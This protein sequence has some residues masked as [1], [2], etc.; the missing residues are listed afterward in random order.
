MNCSDLLFQGLRILNLIIRKAVCKSCWSS[1][2]RDSHSTSLSPLFNLC[3]QIF[4]LLMDVDLKRTIQF[5]LERNVAVVVHDQ[6]DLN[7]SRSR[8]VLLPNAKAGLKEKEKEKASS[9]G[10]GKTNATSQQVASNNDVISKAALAQ[11]ARRQRERD[12]KRQLAKR[13][14]QEREES[15]E[16]MQ[17]TQPRFFPALIPSRR[18]RALLERAKMKAIKVN[19]I[20]STS[21]STEKIENAPQQ[22]VV[23]KALASSSTT[24][25]LS[26]STSLSTEKTENAPQRT[27]VTKALVSSSTTAILSQEPNF[28]H[29]PINGR[30][31][32][33]VRN[34]LSQPK[35]S[36]LHSLPPPRNLGI[37]PG[38]KIIQQGLHFKALGG[39]SSSTPWN[40]SLSNNGGNKHLINPGHRFKM[41]LGRGKVQDN[42]G[43]Y[44]NCPQLRQCPLKPEI[45]LKQTPMQPKYVHFV[46]VATTNY[47]APVMTFP[48]GG[49]SVRDSLGKPGISLHSVQSTCHM[50]TAD[51]PRSIGSKGSDDKQRT[52]PHGGPSVRHSLGKPGIALHAVQSDCHEATAEAPH[53]IGSR[54]SDDKQ[55]DFLGKPGIALHA[56]QSDCH[57]ATAEAPHSIGSRESDD[58]QRDSLGKPGI[59]LHAVQFDCHEATA[60]APH[61]IGS[62]ESDDKQRTLPHGGLSIRDSLGKPGIDMHAV[63]SDFHKATTETPHSIGSKGSEDKQRTEWFFCLPN[64]LKQLDESDQR[65]YKER[66]LHLPPAEL[67][68]HAFELEKRAVQLTIE[69]GKEMQRVQDLNILGNVVDYFNH[70]K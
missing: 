28:V 8:E 36:E 44:A 50:G 59:A 4:L 20:Q 61:S 35:R 1:F 14:H 22:T 24:A 29:N 13:T 16:C 2:L 27:V 46:P 54:E 33:L 23:T 7:L 12:A 5:L 41:E 31:L 19:A 30:S 3:H 48:Y 32:P 47:R 11:R 60:E 37:E 18:R 70:C 51:V 40:F 49:S 56:V 68:R 39:P 38:R 65:D 45:C 42:M 53:S 15:G 58:K 34:M 26:Q 17:P 43:K 57:E 63:Q 64:L 67:S 66:L 6:H 10:K 25:V 52:F 9:S 55:R 62:R 69:E 21:L